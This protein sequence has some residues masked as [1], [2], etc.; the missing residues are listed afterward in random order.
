MA[1]ITSLALLF[2]AAVSS[3]FANSDHGKP[4]SKDVDP[5]AKCPGYRASNVRTTSSTLTA[6]LNLAGPA[7]NVY[8]TDLT[9]LTLSVTYETGKTRSISLCRK[10]C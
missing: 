5:L 2:A 4:P 10:I 6:D 9:H 7:C 3:A 8:G 1:R